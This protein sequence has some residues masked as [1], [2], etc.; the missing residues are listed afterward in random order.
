MGQMTHEYPHK[1][2]LQVHSPRRQKHKDNLLEKQI[3]SIENNGRDQTVHHYHGI[4]YGCVRGAWH[5]WLFGL[6]VCCPVCK[7]SAVA[8]M[9]VL[10]RREASSSSKQTKSI[11]VL[12]L[13]QVT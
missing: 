4:T 2:T 1:K 5:D 3:E 12:L 9:T 6:V 10:F 8:I 11:N 13:Y 7:S